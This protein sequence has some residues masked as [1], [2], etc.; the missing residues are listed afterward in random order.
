MSQSIIMSDESTRA[1]LA[2]KKTL[3]QRVI[4]PQPPDIEGLY[5]LP[6]G[7]EFWGFLPS[8]ERADVPPLRCRYGRP[9]HGNQWGDFM[10][11]KEVWR[12]DGWH[13]EYGITSI[14]YRADGAVREPPEG[15][16][17]PDTGNDLKD[18]DAWIQYW[19]QSTDEAQKALG[20]PAHEAPDE[21]ELCWQW[22]PGHGPC[23]WRS[24]L[25]MPRWASRLSLEITDER[26]RRVQTTNAHDVVAEGIELPNI[27]P[28]RGIT[29]YEGKE[30][31][32]ARTYYS[33]VWD[34]INAKRGHAWETNP[35]V[36]AV[37]FRLLGGSDGNVGA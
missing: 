27:D 30:D 22:E 16:M 5:Y 23:R 1:I 9:R 28:G 20:E 31:D 6:H 21:W 25:F 19:T 15:V 14:Q 36:W 13:P 17:W 10:W 24:P 4:I 12:I 3:T 35:W 34:S 11:V 32:I 8:G 26:V 18:E 7:R 29:W 2:G 37:T 33:R